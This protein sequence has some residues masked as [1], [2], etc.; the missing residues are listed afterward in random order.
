M[1]NQKLNWY[2]QR[3]NTYVWAINALDTRD[4][5]VPSLSL[6]SQPPDFVELMMSLEVII[7]RENEERR[8]H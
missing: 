2:F 3:T 6:L 7:R 8:S 5:A 4:V 1:T